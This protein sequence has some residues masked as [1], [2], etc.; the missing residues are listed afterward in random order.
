MASDDV[1]I[2]YHDDGSKKKGVGSF[3]VQGVS[4]NGIYRAFPTL[5]VAS[6]SCENLV[7]LKKCVLNILE[8]CSGVSAK[9]LFERITF[10]MMDTTSRNFG[11]DEQ[12]SDT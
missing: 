7:K 9:T 12:V 10:R 1:V 3:A 11:V 8:L 2:T 6:E 4:M 5:N